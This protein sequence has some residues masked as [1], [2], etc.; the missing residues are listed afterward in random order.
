[1][2]ATPEPVAEAPAVE[3]TPEPAAEAPAADDLKKVEG[4]GPKISDLLNA[5]DIFTFAQLGATSEERLKEILT[6]AGGIYASKDCSTWAKQSE[7]AAAGKWDELKKWQDE[8]DGGKV[9]APK[10]PEDK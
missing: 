9:V 1:M 10:A 4:I 7:M 5:A 3:A 8:L 2:E 6:A